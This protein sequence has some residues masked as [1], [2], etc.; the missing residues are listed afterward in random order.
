[1]VTTTRAL[2][3]ALLSNDQ[4]H[5]DPKH[6]ARGAATKTNDMGTKVWT[7]SWGRQIYP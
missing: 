1:M 2:I 3:M 7:Q 4:P 6:S 5:I